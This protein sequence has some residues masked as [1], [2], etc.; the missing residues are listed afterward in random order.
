MAFTKTLQ[1]FIDR[2]S[3]LAD[4]RGQVSTDAQ[5]RHPQDDVIQLASDDYRAMRIKAVRLGFSELLVATDPAALSLT[6]A[7]TGEHFS[8]ETAPAA[9]VLLRGVDVLM[10]GEWVT[11]KRATHEQRRLPEVSG[12]KDGH[13]SHWYLQSIGQVA[14]ATPTAGK[15]AILPLP[16]IAAMHRIWYLPE[17][18]VITD[19]TH[20]F[21]YPDQCHYDWHVSKTAWKIAQLRDNDAKK[22]A[23]G[24]KKMET[25]AATEMEEL[26]KERQAD[27]P[28]S[29]YRDPDYNG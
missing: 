3:Y 15:I 18:T 12:R 16:T 19:L 24:L 9:S 8:V 10:R 21:L 5:A 7:A 1:Q 28:L 20:L 14:S 22:R 2:V 26:M 27:G 23:D 17:F 6:A 25:E 29:V 4:I 13:P 11:L